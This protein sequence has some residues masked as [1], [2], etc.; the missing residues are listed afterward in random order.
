MSIGGLIASTSPASS[1][2]RPRDAAGSSLAFQVFG[3]AAVVG[4][5]IALL[6]VNPIRDAR[7]VRAG[8]R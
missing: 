4:A 1:S 8:Q 7:R 2:A 5:V 3:A 6:T